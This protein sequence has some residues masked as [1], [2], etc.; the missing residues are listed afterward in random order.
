MYG[1]YR[2]DN[3]A[4]QHGYEWTAMR[5][6]LI[7]MHC[8]IAAITK[9]ESNTRNYTCNMCKKCKIHEITHM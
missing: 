5:M 7:H 1:S 8:L 6:T 4:V 3:G 9:K 2:A